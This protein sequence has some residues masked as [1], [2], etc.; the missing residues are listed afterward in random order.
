MISTSYSNIKPGQKFRLIGDTH[1]WV[2]AFVEGS[3]QELDS[4]VDLD[5]LNTDTVT[6]TD[7]GDMDGA[8]VSVDREGDV[9]TGNL[10]L[11]AWAQVER[12]LPTTRLTYVEA[13][14]DDDSHDHW[15]IEGYVLCHYTASYWA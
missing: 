15:D 7:H 13:G 4:E 1:A 3:V 10:H 9:V 2:R 11:D 12:V 8:L 6:L 14:H 5:V